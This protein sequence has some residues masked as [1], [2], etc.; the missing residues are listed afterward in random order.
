MNSW[1]GSACFT[2]TDTFLPLFDACACVLEVSFNSRPSPGLSSASTSFSTPSSDSSEVESWVVVMNTF[3]FM[4]ALSTATV[5]GR[6][7]SGQVVPF[8][9]LPATKSPYG[10]NSML[11]PPVGWTLC[12]GSAMQVQL[13][14]F[15]SYAARPKHSSFVAVN[16][17]NAPMTYKTPFSWSNCRAVPTPSCVI[18]FI[19]SPPPGWATKCPESWS[20]TANPA[21]MFPPSIALNLPATCSCRRSESQAR[22]R[23]VT[24]HQ[25][26][27]ICPTG[28]GSQ[29]SL[30]AL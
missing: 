25:L 13:P 19:V 5:Y 7:L 12:A 11:P 3:F 4:V 26:Q 16:R 28:S 18:F 29:T 24:V 2:V 22:A 14:V 20:Y 6:V 17:S 15:I 30:I 9:V 23:I 10:V 21:G 1:S 8:V 27:V